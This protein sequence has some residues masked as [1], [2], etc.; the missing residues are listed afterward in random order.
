MIMNRNTK[1]VISGL[2]ILAAILSFTLMGNAASSAEWSPN[3]KTIESLD[4]KKTT[5]M[6]LTAAST[7]ASVAISMIPGDGGSP[8]ADKLADF[9]GYFLIVLCALYLEKYLLTITGFVAF[10]IL[11]PIALILVIG[12]LFSQKEFLLKIAIK[13]IL[14]GLA[15]FLI[16]PSSEGISGLINKTYQESIQATMDAARETTEAIESEVSETES[17]VSEDTESTT[18]SESGSIFDS[19]GGL[20]NRGAEAVQD[21]ASAIAD[22]ASSLISS[23]SELPAMAEN[24]LNRFIESLAIL[25]VTSCLIPIAVIFFYVWLVKLILGVDINLSKLPKHGHKF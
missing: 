1:L 19:I 14:F 18:E 7:A 5:V 24:V 6:E 25:I 16:V 2:L 20:I 15:I 13:G 22:G 12:W 4:E 10:K 8:I 21:G 3:Q 9:S 17:V 11:I 23:A